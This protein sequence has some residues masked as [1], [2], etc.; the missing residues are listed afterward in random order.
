MY[1]STSIFFIRKWSV[2]KGPMRH[3]AIFRPN[4]DLTR[5]SWQPSALSTSSLVP[6]IVSSLSTSPIQLEKY[7]ALPAE[8]DSCGNPRLIDARCDPSRTLSR[9]V[10]PLPTQSSTCRP[11][12]RIS[13]L[14]GGAVGLIFS[15][16]AEDPPQADLVKNWSGLKAPLTR[17]TKKKKTNHV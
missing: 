6:S 9:D 11:P 14:S 17:A 2:N 4:P 7:S 1:T 10:A 8:I 12:I 15:D 16:N 3:G 5:P 13:C